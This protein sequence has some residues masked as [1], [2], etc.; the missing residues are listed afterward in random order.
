MAHLPVFTQSLQTFPSRRFF[1]LSVWDSVYI[2]Y[3][4]CTSRKWPFKKRGDLLPT[5]S[6]KC[7]F[8]KK[9]RR[10]FSQRDWSAQSRLYM[11]LMASWLCLLYLLEQITEVLKKTNKKKKIR[12]RTVLMFQQRFALL[13]CR[14]VEH[15]LKKKMDNNFKLKVEI[16]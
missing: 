12:W 15:F 1:R 8:W 14:N 13:I 9:K 16:S 2:K 4:C 3:W 6:P 5:F 7:V 10:I 11:A